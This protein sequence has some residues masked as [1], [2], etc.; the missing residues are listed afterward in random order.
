MFQKLKRLFLKKHQDSKPS[1][2]QTHADTP[3]QEVITPVSK[4][5]ITTDIMTWL[6]KHNWNYDHREPKEGKIHHIIMGFSDHEHEW[7]CVFRINEGNQLV[8]VLGILDD[9]MPISHYTALLMELAKVNMNVS[10]GSIEFDP[11]DGEIHAKIAFDAEFGMLT[12]KALGNYMQALSGL[13]EVARGIVKMVLMDD[14]PSQFAGD[15]IEMGDEVS[16]VIDD[17]KRTFFLATHTSQ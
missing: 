11:N 4:H 1:T 10:F 8:T 3:T 7:T 5:P 9:N 15:Y 6:D 14:E 17:E 12:D 13:T 2:T 16:A